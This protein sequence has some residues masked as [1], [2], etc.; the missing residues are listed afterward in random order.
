MSKP[1]SLRKSYR[2]RIEEGF[3]ETMKLVIGDEEIE[4]TKSKSLRYGE[5]PH[6][7]AAFYSPSRGPLT[8][9]AMKVLKTGKGGLS[10]TNLED[11]NN[12]MNIVRYFDEPAC[13]VMK[14]LNPSGVATLRGPGDTL[15]EVYA[16]ARDCDSLAAFGSVV[17]FNTNV[18]KG[19]AEEI[20]ASYVEGV[21][22]PA[23]DNKALE[24]FGEKKDLRVIQVDNLREMSRFA[25]EPLRPVMVSMQMDGSIVLSAPM[26]TKIRGPKD[27]RV[28]TERRPTDEQFADLIFSWY[29]CMNVRSNGVVISKGRATLGVSTGQQ[30]RIAAVRLALEKVMARG[31]GEEL[32]G[33]VLASDGFFPFRDSI[34]LLADYGVAA[35]VQPGGSIRD[36][37]VRKAS[38]ENGIAMVLTDERCFRHF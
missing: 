6:Q 33:S 14:H 38:D 10:Q 18:D 36:R 13:A 5:N 1:K 2:T 24:L 11:V 3:P 23:Y 12:S 28:V 30:D 26:L 35:C 9:G 17:G 20:L 7:P 34:D 29:V 21:V 8:T 16:R 22:A 31:H 32:P 19:T 25:G 37:S 27:L 15:R 4:Y